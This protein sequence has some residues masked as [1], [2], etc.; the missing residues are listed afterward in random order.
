[1]ATNE[2]DRDLD[3]FGDS[4]EAGNSDIGVDNIFGAD[5]STDDSSDT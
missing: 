2:L 3:I 1:M 5:D 4:G